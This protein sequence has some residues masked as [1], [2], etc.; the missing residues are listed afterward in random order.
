V[1]ITNATGRTSVVD[2]DPQMREHSGIP[3]S[4]TLKPGNEFEK[5]E[6]LGELIRFRLKQQQI[7]PLADGEYVIA[8]CYNSVKGPLD[9]VEGKDL[10]NEH[11][12]GLLT[13]ANLSYV[14]KNKK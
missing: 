2:F 7:S 12:N 5:K 9:R 1:E 8:V 3:V 6:N 11:W 4:V 10:Q 14:F 13:V